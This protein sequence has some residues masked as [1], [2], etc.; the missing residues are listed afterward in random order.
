MIFPNFCH[1]IVVSTLDRKQEEKGEREEVEDEVEKEIEE[2]I[3]LAVQD[4]LKLDVCCHELQVKPSGYVNRNS[5]DLV[6]PNVL[7]ADGVWE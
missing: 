2:E 5:H 4:V 7:M 3:S 1:R 6:H